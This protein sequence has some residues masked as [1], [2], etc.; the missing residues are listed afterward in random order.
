MNYSSNK[1]NKLQAIKIKR[2]FL[3]LGRINKYWG[4]MVC[5]QTIRITR[6]IMLIC[7]LALS[8]VIFVQ[9]PIKCAYPQD[10]SPIFI[11]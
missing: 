11:N 2:Y 4:N 3:I 9:P 1:K 7:K 5:A 8:L 10:P 6:F